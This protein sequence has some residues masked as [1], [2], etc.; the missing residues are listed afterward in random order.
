MHCINNK[1]V[2]WLLLTCSCIPHKEFALSNRRELSAY[3]RKKDNGDYG[4]GVRLAS[5]KERILGTIHQLASYQ[6]GMLQISWS[7]WN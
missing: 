2:D 5:H 4:E 3:Y 1:K 6:C 7:V